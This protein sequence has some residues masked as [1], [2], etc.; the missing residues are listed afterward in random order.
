MLSFLYTQDTKKEITHPTTGE[1]YIDLLEKDIVYGETNNGPQGIAYYLVTGDTAMRPD[2]ISK[3]MYG[4]FDQ[5]EK[6]LKFNGISNPLSLEEGDILIQWDI[7]SLE[8]NMR[9]QNNEA[10]NKV[11][12]RKQYIT[13]EKKSKIDPALKEF[14][15]RLKAKKLPDTALPPNYA[16]FGEKEIELRNGVMV[17][18]ANVSKSSNGNE[19][20]EPLSRTEYIKNLVK[21]RTNL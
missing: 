21:N 9:S 17:F 2:L 16:N 5:V 6:I 19:G 4:N 1:K 3:T 15:K 18:G 8:R 13:P 11:D 12:V 14:N 7:F 20:N 10:Q